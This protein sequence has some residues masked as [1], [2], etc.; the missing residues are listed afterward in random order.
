MT[1]YCDTCNKSYKSM[2]SLKRH[3]KEKHSGIEY[4]A[5]TEYNCSS[6]FIRRNYLS[7]HLI[8]KHKFQSSK[9]KETAINVPRGDKEKQ[10]SGAYYEDISE[11]ESIFSL[12]QEMEGN[13]DNVS[14]EYVGAISNFDI[15]LLQ[16]PV[17]KE[18]DTITY[19][20][21]M[22]EEINENVVDSVEN[23]CENKSVNDESDKNGVKCGE[24]ENCVKNEKSV[25]SR[26]LQND[27]ELELDYNDV[28]DC[29]NDDVMENVDD[30]TSTSN[31]KSADINQD[32]IYDVI[33]NDNDVMEND[34]DV[35]NDDNSKYDENNNQTNTIFIYEDISDTE[36]D[37]WDEISNDQSIVPSNLQTRVQTLTLTFCK[38]STY[39][40]EMEI[41][42]YISASHDYSEDWF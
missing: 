6:R 34:D 18:D 7:K 36:V 17:N 28:S 21:T 4:F 26:V 10:H 15:S 30:V 20:S 16:E 33:E 41:D 25:L 35:T 29:S 27:S 2:R 5:C 38:I 22:S 3:I 8:L 37:H 19:E 23:E 13:G 39:S 31:L 1:V 32:K 11:D 40:N 42:S 14:L 9:A 24:K 12:I